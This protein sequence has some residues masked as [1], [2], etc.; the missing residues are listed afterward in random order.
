MKYL[1]QEVI[2]GLEKYKYN[3][4]DT[5]P[6]SNYVMHPLWNQ[7]VKLF[8]RWVA[9]NV[10]TVTGFLLIVVN[11]GLLTYYDYDFSASSDSI[12]YTSPIP[13]W[14][15]LV[16][17]INHFLSH[18]L[19][20]IDGKQARRTGTSGPLGELMDHGVDSWAAFFL[21]FSIYSMFGR[22]ELSYPPIRV[23]FIF[24][25]IFITF[26]FSHWEK[27]NTGILY[28]PWSYDATQLALTVLYLVTYLKSYHVWKIVLPIMGGQSLGQLFEYISYLGSF[29]GS[30]P[31]TVFN[32]YLA[33]KS[34]SLKRSLFEGLRPLISFVSLF[35]I[36][37]YWALFSPTNVLNRDPR[38]FFALVGTIFSQIACRLIINQMSSTR[39]QAFNWFLYPLTAVT[40]LCLN[41]KTFADHELEILR[42]LTVFFILAHIHYGVSI[43]RQ[44]CAHFNINCFTIKHQ[45]EKV[46]NNKKK[47]TD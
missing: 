40:V 31:F 20:G 45:Y 5:S 6:L 25:T 8:P 44:L 14:V 23:L 27:Y 3:S 18:N 22:G 36:S 17:S 30:V 29:A 26:Y 11:A 24:W 9:P 16:C 10:L 12:P 15:W 39:C 41:V 21:P 34:N 19:D 37:T 43:T 35:L 1:D 42:A 28:L 13:S 2:K 4:I 47:E 46:P 7:L 33:Y 38:F 32:V